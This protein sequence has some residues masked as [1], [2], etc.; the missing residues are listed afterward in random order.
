MS[1]DAGSAWLSSVAV[2]GDE[3]EGH[4]HL[5]KSLVVRYPMLEL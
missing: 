1:Q 3:S 5:K 2:V 4:L